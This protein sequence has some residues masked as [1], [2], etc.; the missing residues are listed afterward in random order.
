MILFAV[1]V[2]CRFQ[3][4]IM[5]SLQKKRKPAGTEMFDR[6]ESQ[7]ATL[8]WMVCQSGVVGSRVVCFLI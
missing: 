5:L 7:N 3:D 4:D 2:K 1:K 6:A 8:W